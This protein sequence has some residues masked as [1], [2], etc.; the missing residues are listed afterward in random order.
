MVSKRRRRNDDDDDD[1]RPLKYRKIDGK[2]ERIYSLMVNYAHSCN[3]DI[4]LRYMFPR[5]DLQ[6]AANDHD[7]LTAP[8]TQLWILNSIEVLL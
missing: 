5:A 2:K 4:N 3:H 6:V 7:Y 1:P 8:F